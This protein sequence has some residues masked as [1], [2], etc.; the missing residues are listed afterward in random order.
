MDPI[1]TLPGVR[2]SFA[3]KVFD[4]LTEDQKKAFGITDA[5][6]EDAKITIASI[7]KPWLNN[8]ETIEEQNN[9]IDHPETFL[10]RL[11]EET[12]VILNDE[13]FERAEKELTSY[14]AQYAEQLSHLIHLEDTTKE[15]L[16]GQKKMILN[17]F[18]TVART[19][20]EWEDENDGS[21]HVSII[22]RKPVKS[23]AIPVQD[24]TLQ[25]LDK[26]ST[27]GKEAR[28]VG[29]EIKNNKTGERKRWDKYKTVPDGWSKTGRYYWNYNGRIILAN[30]VSNEVHGFKDEYIENIATRLGNLLDKFG[31]QFFDRSSAL[32]QL[33]DLRK[34][35]TK[36]TLTDEETAKI[37]KFITDEMQDIYTVSGLRNL[38]KDFLELES[39]IQ[40]RWPKA[41]MFSGD[42]RMFA[43][44]RGD[45]SFVTGAPDLIVVDKEGRLHVIDFKTWRIGSGRNYQTLQEKPESEYSRREDYSEQIS[46]YIRILQSQGFDVEESPYIVQV[47]TYYESSS[48]FELGKGGVR[49]KTSKEEG[50]PTMSLS[51]YAA[52]E[53]IAEDENIRSRAV[54]RELGNDDTRI[55]YIEPRLHLGTRPDGG[56]SDELAALR[57]KESLD[58]DEWVSFER[59][60][61]SID[62]ILQT[63]LD[64]FAGP[65]VHRGMA[66]GIVRLPEADIDSRPD[67][68]SQEEMQ[69]I[70]TGIMYRASDIIT[71]LIQGDEWT[72][73]ELQEA[74]PNIGTTL[75]GRT[76]KEV[77]RTIGIDKLVRFIFDKHINSYDPNMP[78]INSKEEFERQADEDGRWR[79]DGYVFRSWKSYANKKSESDRSRWMIH[80]YDQ[81]IMKGQAKLKALEGITCP[82]RLEE[83]KLEQNGPNLGVDTD[84]SV[85][86]DDNGDNDVITSFI[87]QY[88]EG[89]SNLEAWMMGQRNYSPKASLAKEIKRMFEDIILVD[90]DGEEILD[91][92]GWQFPQHLDATKAVQACL[93]ICKDCETIEEM[94]TALQNALF[95]PKNKWI[96]Q[97]LDKI[98]APGNENLRTKFFR[99]MR[100]DA[101]LYSVA[102]IRVENGQRVVQ[103]R[104]INMKTAYQTMIQSLNAS[105][106]NGS[107]GSFRLNEDTNPV[108]LIRTDKYGNNILSAARDTNVAA[109]IDKEAEKLKKEYEGIADAVNYRRYKREYGDAALSYSQYI[110]DKL[111]QGDFFKRLTNVLNGIGVLV[112]EDI[113]TSAALKR[114][115]QVVSGNLGQM[116]SNAREVCAKLRKMDGEE[117][118]PKGLKGNT[119]FAFYEPILSILG[120]YVQEHIEAC[121]YQDG[122]TYFTY[123]NPSRLG[124]IVRNLKDALMQ[125]DERSD[126]DK[127]RQFLFDHFGRFKGWYTTNEKKPK[128]MVDWLAQ[129][130]DFKSSRGRRARKALLHKVELS[131]MGDQYRDLGPL[132]FQRSLLHNYFGSRA[133]EIEGDGL[134]RWFG[135]PTMSNKPTNE[136][137]RM[138]KY[139]DSDEI[140]KKVLKPTFDQEMNRIADVLYHYACNAVPTDQIDLVDINGEDKL[141]NAGMSAQE[142]KELKERILSQSITLEDLKKLIPLNSGAKFHFLWY[143]N[144][145]ILNDQ[146]STLED[147]TLIG[148]R[149]VDRINLLLSPEDSEA[150]QNKD[151]NYEAETDEAIVNLIN[152]NMN[153]VRDDEGNIIRK[154]LIDIEMEHMEE[155][156]L[157][158]KE[159]KRVMGHEVQVLKYQN[160][161]GGKLGRIRTEEVGKHFKTV[162]AAVDE[163]EREFREGLIDYIWQDIAANINIIQI[164]GGDLAFYGNSVNYQKRI[165]MIHSPG[166]HLMHNDKYDDGFL[167]SVHISDDDL[168]SDVKE[169]ALI[170]LKNYR[171]S[172]QNESQKR[173][174]DMMI[175]IITSGFDSINTTDGQSFGC[176]SSERKKLALMGEWTDEDEEAYNKVLNGDLSM[177]N[178]GAMINPKKPKKPFVASD[179][180]KYSGSPT[181]TLR[182]VPLQDKNSEYLIILAE[183]LARQSGKRSKL[184][185]ISDFME[186]T[187]K[188]GDGKHG[189]DT[190]HF[191]SVGKVGVSGVI[192]LKYFD[193]HY[194]S[195]YAKA[196]QDRSKEVVD[197]GH[198][199]NKEEAYN[200]LLTSYL[201]NKVKRKESSPNDPSVAENYQQQQTLNQE[202]DRGRKMLKD[203][204]LYYDSDYVDT[205]PV[206]D[207]IIQQEV[208]AHLLDEHEQL[209][210]SQI[211]I[212]GISDITPGT[213]FNVKG[214]KMSDEE[215]V[216]EY[217]ELHADN[218]EASFD[219]LMEE[220][221]LNELQT[222]N[223]QRI[224]L[225]Q[226][227]QQVKDRIYT[228]IATILQ[229]ELVMDGK[230]SMDIQKACRLVRNAA[231]VR[232]FAVPLMD[233]IQAKRVQMLINS[234]IKKSINKQGINGGPVVQATAYDNRLH[235]RFQDANGN[236][237]MSFD[238]FQKANENLTKPQAIKAFREYL[239]EKQAGIAY[240]ECYMP[241]PN[242]AL[243]RLMTNP[244]G[245]IMTIEEIQKKLPKE[246][247][248]SLSEAIGYRIPTEDK[249]SML[250]LKIMGFVP[251]AAGEVIMMPQEITYLTGSDF[252]IDKMYIMLKSF[253]TST[254]SID[255]V[256]STKVAIT[257][258][259]QQIIIDINGFTGDMG[260]TEAE[261]EAFMKAVEK[262]VR[263]ADRI[264]TG[265]YERDL[266]SGMSTKEKNILTDQIVRVGVPQPN[267]LNWFRDQLLQNALTEYTDKEN[268]F[269][270]AARQARNN[271]LLD[272]QWAVLTNKDT[273][274]KMLN[275]GNF[276]PQKKVGRMIRIIKSGLAEDQT[277]EEWDKMYGMKSKQLD[278]MLDK[279]DPHSVTLPSSKIYFQRQNMQGTQ[280]VGIFANNNVSH[281][282]MTFQKVGIDLA[283]GKYDKSF[284]FDGIQI[285]SHE[286]PTVLDP[287]RGRNGQLIS[288][289]IASFLAAAV[290][291]AKDPTLA[292]MN[293]N[294]FT[295]GVAMALA[296]MGFDTQEIGLFL[297]QPIIME[298]TNLY[299]RNKSSQVFYTGN[300]AVEELM[301]QMGLQRKDFWDMN[302][303]KHPS[304]LTKENL[305]RHLTDSEF[306][307]EKNADKSSRE[308][309]IAVLKAFDSLLNIARDLQELTFCT[310]FN[311]VTNAVGP[312][313][314]DTEEDKQKVDNF[315][316]RLKETV[317]YIPSNNPIENP[318]GFTNPGD[319]ISK[320]PILQAFYETT[321]GNNGASRRIFENFFLNYTEGFQNVLDFF[322]E[323]YLKNG[324]IDSK[325]YNKLM[326]DYLYYCLTYRNP[327]NT[328]KPV[329]PSDNELHDEEEGDMDYLV[330][331]LVSRYRDIL[332]LQDRRSMPNMLLDQHLGNNCLRIREKD[333][334]IT[335]DI[336]EFNS[337]QMNTEN[338]DM[339]RRAW[340]AIL[341]MNDPNLSDEENRNIQRFGVDLFFYSL[342]R[343][344]FGFSPKTL[345]HLATVIVR[346]SAK[347]GD[348]FA[349]YIE[350]LQQL[351]IIVD[352]LTGSRLGGFGNNYGHL[353]RFCDMFVRNHSNNKNIVPFVERDSDI[354]DDN[355]TTSDTLVLSVP[356]K[357]TYRLKAFMLNNK[358]PL[359]FVNL[360]SRTSD[361]MHYDLYEIDDSSTVS[362]E[363]T[364]FKTIKYKKTTRLGITNQFI[365]YN[366]NDEI[367]QSYFDSIRGTSDAGFETEEE[368]S[369]E[370]TKVP[371]QEDEMYDEE[372][373]Q[374]DALYE[375]IKKLHGG[376]MRGGGTQG[377]A[378]F[379]QK[380]KKAF[381]SKER[382]ALTEEFEI[383][384]SQ[385]ASE[386]EKKAAWERIKSVRDQIDEIIEPQNRCKPV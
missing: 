297:S 240:Y 310:K 106:T 138:L 178:L 21:Y 43:P 170:A 137:I 218:I 135:L 117:G 147:N 95:D 182:K 213:E 126:N 163:A 111:L 345:M 289:T 141:A 140:V 2:E 249:Y 53:G 119:A 283:K 362:K 382:N 286:S 145:G 74:F 359:R 265:D 367:K 159:T 125:Y 379:R 96:Q 32:W 199:L 210:G 340:D 224:L 183:A 123:S 316:G 15:G 219:K 189:I 68:I 248:Q 251:K 329:L 188:D 325:L 193:E 385:E 10:N 14:D 252:D 274:S 62:Q 132:S 127:V 50:A 80:H 223:G 72:E 355:A 70:A 235:I 328:L 284:Y 281:A 65:V 304:T 153:G 255:K 20:R 327:T 312:T 157:L 305:I 308:Y 192:D 271:R 371:Q 97:V 76:R 136:F 73:K 83:G 25:A 277:L 250:P 383:L 118:I 244:D 99:H 321:L 49:V 179:M 347:F 187:H 357:E 110:A 348:D 230:Y 300:N 40:N 337:S 142:I 18:G 45:K 317:F 228:K 6:A 295:G 174:Y 311:S 12:R 133:D 34:L 269:P 201:L 29:I 202:D 152:I 44:N 90:E 307:D 155:I 303:I 31:R 22:I 93:D 217:K 200:A 336:L 215:L 256:D 131:F 121:T 185:A 214:Q 71:K 167:R 69:T 112:T 374:W 130:S 229:R 285:G 267:F 30:S 266:M 247:W 150:Q 331:S 5:T 287:Q 113:V 241:I 42:L 204:E 254:L 78:V 208:P 41:K 148:Q 144:N 335:Q 384:L 353:S 105:F 319:V 243:E 37:Q 318:E 233:P 275:P 221:G 151:V 116:I 333:E 160:E 253:E 16:E 108:S 48:D 326:D 51:Q 216:K 332:K 27:V 24:R 181:M 369:E 375:E 39:Q 26:L 351:P 203:E 177:E 129:L 298:L 8:S 291:T 290:D 238:E 373:S 211:R 206:E 104:I 261:R 372:E 280:M 356:E 86:A 149:I 195:I 365:E 234:I 124:H 330:K 349:N 154:G 282:F 364:G 103:T 9:K 339:V 128:F 47:D 205:I 222:A 87:D 386:D 346:F 278:K 91:P 56:M 294:T 207:Y 35:A 146:D 370:A 102:Q 220:L 360:V 59:Q 344:G 77:I 63:A 38:I 4:I 314:A 368:N 273:A 268:G 190:T 194:D 143:L 376:P 7:A 46:Y 209:Y 260:R 109:L 169:N 64:D 33:G 232:G 288:K 257:K 54:Q 92:Y 100:K 107:V 381:E 354:V 366:A 172:L 299:F 301:S 272:L 196:V 184:S 350:G 292:D 66:Q 309:Q 231:G 52:Q 134:Y 3:Q 242:P 122:K 88:T 296:R 94:E 120:D 378:T 279:G 164:T 306:I 245:T 28:A 156:G 227:P 313:I 323:N 55:L 11:F 60:Y 180:A 58:F 380:L 361:G 239:E 36:K 79:R 114:P 341:Q 322:K 61:E 293:I 57:G 101:F 13:A 85:F 82:V 363:G 226:A 198:I 352:A 165:A 212:L 158:D 168:W 17:F 162:E 259:S 358:E 258:G 262:L 98:N 175:N 276:E 139:K 161:F 343:N 342:M 338:E 171:D 246:V 1:C 89:I 263:N 270:P 166:I 225:D 236:I 176:I 191:M 334:Y 237:L 67:I 264:L 320:D 84:P 19:V 377:D 75:R 81:L 115:D 302:D 324:K 173:E 197:N 186:A 315:M 23:T